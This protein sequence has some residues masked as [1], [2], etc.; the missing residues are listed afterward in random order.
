MA[1]VPE[2]GGRNKEDKVIHQ[3]LLD[4][5]AREFPATFAEQVGDVPLGQ[6]FHQALEVAVREGSLLPRC[7]CNDCLFGF[8]IVQDLERFREAALAGHDHPVRVPPA[9]WSRKERGIIEAGGIRSDHDGIYLAAQGL[10][11]FA[12][13]GAG[14]P[15]GLFSEIRDASIETHGQFQGYMRSTQGDEAAPG[16]NQV[17]PCGLQDSRMYLDTALPQEIKAAPGVLRVGVVGGY[18]DLFDAG[19]E[20]GFHAGRRSPAG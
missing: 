1:P 8:G 13:G 12:C 20:N 18:I 4:Q 16:A 2:Q 15:L 10:R 9:R 7:T 5:G 14:D 11:R 6:L 19:R 3:P 17:P